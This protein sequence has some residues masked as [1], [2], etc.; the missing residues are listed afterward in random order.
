[1]KTILIEFN[2]HELKFMGDIINALRMVYECGV[3]WDIK[4]NEEVAEAC[5]LILDKI[6]DAERKLKENE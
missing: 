3:K 4:R 6:E 5:K 1:M 2:E